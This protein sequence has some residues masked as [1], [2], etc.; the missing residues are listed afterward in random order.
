[1]KSK[2]VTPNG[3]SYGGDLQE[4]I[5]HLTNCKITTEKD[6]YGRP[7]KIFFSDIFLKKLNL[8]IKNKMLTLIQ[9]VIL[10]H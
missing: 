4:E 6:K 5:N 8:N 7:R 9:I 1:M 3:S 2:S 10:L